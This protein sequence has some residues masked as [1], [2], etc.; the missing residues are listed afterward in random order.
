M[1]GRPQVVLGAREA[2]G[3]HSVDDFAKVWVQSADRERGNGGEEILHVFHQG[4]LFFLSFI[5]FG[6]HAFTHLTLNLA[7]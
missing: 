6:E 7:Q 1:V 4:S 5:F 3:D 2:M